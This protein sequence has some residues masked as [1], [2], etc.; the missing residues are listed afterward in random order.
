MKN[1][2]SR[3]AQCRQEGPENP[4][5]EALR[6]QLA[7]ST[8]LPLDRLQHAWQEC[9]MVPNCPVDV[10]LLLGERILK[11][12]EPILAYDVLAPGATEG[13]GSDNP[14]PAEA[15][16]RLRLRQLAAL[17][18][19]QSGA[20]RRAR[21]L[22]VQLYD[23]GQDNAETLGLLGRVYK[24]LAAAAPTENERRE[25]WLNAYGCYAKGF[26][27]SEALYRRDGARNQ[28]EDAYYCGINAAAV[29]VFLG[30]LAMA[31]TLADR[32]RTICEG[33]LASSKDMGDGQIYWLVATLGEAEL[34]SGRWDQAAQW[35]QAAV[36]RA[37][38]NSRELSST[39][40]QA[41]LL[42]G[43]LGM[44][45][46]VLDSL[47]PTQTVVVLAA[48]I[49][50]DLAQM[51]STDWANGLRFEL[52]RRMEQFT[53]AG[54]IG[55]VSPFDLLFAEAL[56]ER[57]AEAHI[58]LPYGRVECRQLFA[59]SSE[60]QDRFDRVLA[61]AASITEDA[62]HSTLDG[63]VNNS[64]AGLRAYGSA[65][66]RARH[67]AAA[68]QRWSL[69]WTPSAPASASNSLLDHWRNLKC[70]CMEIPYAPPKMAPRAARLG[71][72]QTDPVVD[73]GGS[74][75][76]LAMLFAD[77]RGYSKL[78][79]AALFS[80]GR[81]FTT[82]VAQAL[83]PHAATIVLRRTAGDGVFV[84]FR[85]LQAAAEA[86]FA[87]RDLLNNAPWPKMA[88]PRYLGIRISLDAGPVY[89]FRNAVLQQL[90]VCGKYVNRAA[91]IE[92]I[93]PPNEVYASEAF[94]TLYIAGEADT[95]S[96]AYVG[97]T[98]LPKGFGLAP[99]YCVGRN[100][101]G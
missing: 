36:K 93:T 86:A 85:S 35:Y 31:R 20:A 42:A 17:A 81:F 27:R 94:T 75:E 60:W 22:L 41:R 87:L 82:V 40:R 13:P 12:G 62:E 67:L 9:C 10:R 19:S 7:G 70:S 80:F 46:S 48:P 72:S 58:V 49:W 89:T 61:H 83:E 79:D 1:K 28:G 77:V 96:F 11:H 95:F 63:R 47:F 57:Q 68:L 78:G 44:A 34:I 18:L 69:Q 74:H 21:E 56:F 90:D 4:I 37:G 38:G 101:A 71:P 59:A 65:R 5:V 14:V 3:T 76:I 99:L 53:V 52:G 2:S 39:R 8:D 24:D 64:F 45:S 73:A 66:Q 88:L 100:H 25:H 6:Q 91:R 30:D 51:P 98:Q 55:A 29:R 26:E 84:V 15:P 50:G 16:M 23:E 97:Q 92:P 54:Y 43:C 33:L 32:V